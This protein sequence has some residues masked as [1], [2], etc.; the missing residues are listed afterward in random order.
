MRNR[1]GNKRRKIRGIWKKRKLRRGIRMKAENRGK[2]RRIE[3]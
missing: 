1:E 3:G 2:I